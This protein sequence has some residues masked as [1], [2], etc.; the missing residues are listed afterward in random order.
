MQP[1]GRAAGSVSPAH[2]IL[3]A[4]ATPSHLAESREHTVGSIWT[5]AGAVRIVSTF[6]RSALF[7]G[8][9]R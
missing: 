4:R 7:H 9:G 1:R 6:V 3:G 2:T 8:G 5:R